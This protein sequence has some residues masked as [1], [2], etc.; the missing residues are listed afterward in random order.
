MYNPNMDYYLEWKHHHALHTLTHFMGN[1][2][3]GFAFG[4]LAWFSPLP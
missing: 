4:H 3:A 1:G 2:L